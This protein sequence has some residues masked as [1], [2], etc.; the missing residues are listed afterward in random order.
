MADEMPPLQIGP[1]SRPR[2]PRS[3]KLRHDAGRD[4]WVVL[5]PEKV[6]TPNEVALE[7]LKL[8]DGDRDVAAIANELAKTYNA[9]AATIQEQVLALLRELAA[10]G[11]VS[12]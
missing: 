3:V 10:K 4:R 5:A 11:V 9:P 8:C 6:F 7:V 12:A 2:L 1:A